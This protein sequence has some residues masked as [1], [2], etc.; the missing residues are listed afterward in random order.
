MNETLWE[1]RQVRAT[2]QATKR[3]NSHF[4]NDQDFDAAYLND[5]WLPRGHRTE[6]EIGDHALGGV[7][8]FLASAPIDRYDAG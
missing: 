8:M 5:R 7:C 3:G 2:K 4:Q 1:V 6:S